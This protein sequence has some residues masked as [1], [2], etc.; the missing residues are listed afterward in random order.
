MKTAARFIAAHQLNP[1]AEALDELDHV[2]HRLRRRP[3]LLFENR[4]AIRHGGANRQVGSR[5]GNVEPYSDIPRLALRPA[6]HSRFEPG[7]IET[8]SSRTSSEIR[9]ALST[10]T[11][12]NFPVSR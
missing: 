1:A 3:R 5:P 12:V 6:R 8:G 10:S 11:M 7:E 4:G 2:A 9:R